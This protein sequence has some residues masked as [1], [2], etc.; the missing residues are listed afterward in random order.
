MT[1]SK[2]DSK[3]NTFDVLLILMQSQQELVEKYDNFN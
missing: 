3:A 2:Y 1:K